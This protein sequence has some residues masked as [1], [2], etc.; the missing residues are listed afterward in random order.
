MLFNLNQLFKAVIQLFFSFKLALWSKF[1]KITVS[2]KLSFGKQDFKYFT[3]DKI[4]KKIDLD[5]Y[6]IH[7]WLYIRILLKIDALTF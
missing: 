1:L 5:A 6:F 2:Y 7:T 3:G 4:L